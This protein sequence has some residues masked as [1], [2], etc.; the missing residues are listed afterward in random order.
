MAQGLRVYYS[1]REPEFKQTGRQ[2]GEQPHTHTHT[3]T[4]T[5]HTEL[6]PRIYMGG[7]NWLLYTQ[8]RL[9]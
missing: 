5:H 7:E 4:H 3:H 2:A 6:I 9:M 1:G 8:N